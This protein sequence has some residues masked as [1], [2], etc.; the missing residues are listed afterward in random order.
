MP[1]Q[2]EEA[3]AKFGGEFICL[4]GLL[5]P[6]LFWAASVSSQQQRPFP[7]FEFT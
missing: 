4:H 3:A 7:A 2:Q 6:Q 5:T 1:P